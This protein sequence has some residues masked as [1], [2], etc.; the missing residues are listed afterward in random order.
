MSELVACSSFWCNLPS[1]KMQSQ[2]QRKHVVVSG[3]WH[4]LHRSDGGGRALTLIDD[5]VEVWVPGLL[6]FLCCAFTSTVDG[7]FS[8]LIL[9][10]T[11]RRPLL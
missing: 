11:C 7:I 4:K 2:A 8:L 1:Q 6:E 10:S 9:L 3:F 5:V